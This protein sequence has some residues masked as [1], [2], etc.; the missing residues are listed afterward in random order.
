MVPDTCVYS[1]TFNDQ[2]MNV[3]SNIT[4]MID[5]VKDW[6]WGPLLGVLAWGWSHLSKRSDDLKK[7]TDTQ[8]SEVRTEVNR[9]REISAKIFD[10]L[11]THAQ[12]SDDRHFEAIKYLHEGLAKKVDK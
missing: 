8:V 6:I 10:K 3:D 11:E 9:Q 12:R 7:Y 1:S 4:S 2:A 5:F